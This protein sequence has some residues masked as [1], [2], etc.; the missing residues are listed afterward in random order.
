MIIR[1]AHKATLSVVA[2][3][4]I[5]SSGIAGTALAQAYRYQLTSVTSP[6]A[7]RPAAAARVASHVATKPGASA[8][9]AGNAVALL[10]TSASQAATPTP[11]PTPPATPTSTAT[12]T[13]PAPT[14]SPPASNNPDPTTS[15]P[16]SK[17]PSPSASPTPTPTPTKSPTPTPTKSPKPT[18]TPTPKPAQLC[19]LV[20]PFTSSHVHPGGTASYEVWV[21]STVTEAQHVSV[22]VTIGSVAHVDAPRFTVCPKSSGNVCTVGT[23]PTGQ[24]EEL[25]AVA[26]V[27]RAAA[28]GERVT[29]TATARAT[30]AKSFRSSATVNVVAAPPP[31]VPPVP[32]LPAG[33]LPPGSLPPLPGGP[34]SPLNNDPSGLF[35]TVS[36]ASPNAP[37]NAVAGRAKKVLNRSST[38]EVSATLPL[39]TRLIGGQLVGL[40]VL[41]TAIAIAIARLS[42]R[43]PR[44]HDGGD[45]AK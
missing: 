37:S 8:Q 2:G 39:S 4:F 14:T 18:P 3:I 24:S 1:R 28:S 9:R 35:P 22:T 32:N 19:V 42:L 16:A 20:R 21:W 27:R 13:I 40:A 33:T 6:C 43:G 15:P 36:P 12:P 41:A 30:K 45:A 38:R 10:S 17:S 26:S 29:L 31:A 7:H 11:T 44:P 34:L 23:L 5:V 25:V